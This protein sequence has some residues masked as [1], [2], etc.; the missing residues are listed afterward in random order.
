MK[1][2]ICIACVVTLLAGTGIFGILQDWFTGAVAKFEKD[3]KKG[4]LIT[5]LEGELAKAHR[6]P[7][8]LTLLPH[9][10]EE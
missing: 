9:F 10:I 8:N 1:A 4:T 5:R 7:H 2:K 6:Q 3:L